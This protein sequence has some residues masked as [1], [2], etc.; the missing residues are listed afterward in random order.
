MKEF[1]RSE[2]LDEDVFFRVDEMKD[3]FQINYTRV[4]VMS[5]T[6]LLILV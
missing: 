4:T 6:I 3:V 1:K 2:K 5:V